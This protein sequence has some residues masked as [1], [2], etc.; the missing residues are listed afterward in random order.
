MLVIIAALFICCI[1]TI[2]LEGFPL[3]VMRE[4][5][6]WFK[7]SLL[8]NVVT[9][10]ILNSSLILCTYFMD[11]KQNELFVM[12]V[13]EVVVVFVEAV[14]YSKMLNKEFWKCFIV[15]LVLNAL[16][17]FI[18]LYFAKML[19]VAPERIPSPIWDD[20]N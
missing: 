9:N 8:C 19:Y 5:K 18:G 7:A 16:S 10:P 11:N 14:I 15:S 4:R 20:L 13:F 12:I 1:A 3:I 2:L 6:K 17:F